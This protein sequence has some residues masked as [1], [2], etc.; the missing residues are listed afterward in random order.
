[1]FEFAVQAVIAA[2]AQPVAGVAAI[3]LLRAKV[4]L[5]R[6]FQVVNP[7]TITQQQV[8]FTQGVAAQA[9]RQVGRDQLNP[10]RMF[11]GKLPEPLVI[12]PQSARGG[13][14]QPLLQ[15]LAVLVQRSQ[16]VLQL[17]RCLHPV[18]ASQRVALWP[19]GLAEHGRGEDHPRQI[20]HLRVT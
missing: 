5:D 6:Q 4:Q 9:D 10:R 7:V 11:D 13:Q 8:Q 3:G 19:R 14:R 17:V 18:A 1:M 15:R 12:A 20:T 2:G 16:P